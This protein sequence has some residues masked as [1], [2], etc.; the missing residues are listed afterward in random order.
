M[1]SGLSR[2]ALILNFSRGLVDWSSGKEAKSSDESRHNPDL[3]ESS[4]HLLGVR[5]LQS[6]YHRMD[7]G[8]T[9]LSWILG[10]PAP[11]IK[12]AALQE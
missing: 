5:V 8:P 2:L 6:R 7:I 1:Q 4:F 11:I 10:H 12:A 9:A 3:E